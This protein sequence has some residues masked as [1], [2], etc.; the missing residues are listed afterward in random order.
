MTSRGFFSDNPW[1]H[2]LLAQTLIESCLNTH[3]FST[4]VLCGKSGTWWGVGNRISFIFSLCLFPPLSLRAYV[5][6]IIS[7]QGSIFGSTDNKEAV[8]NYFYR[9]GKFP[10]TVQVECMCF[11]PLMNLHWQ[12][13]Q[14]KMSRMCRYLAITSVMTGK[15]FLLEICKRVMSLLQS[16]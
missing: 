9:H 11:T 10:V 1:I 5:C 13:T 16:R 4:R 6:W 8:S 3:L 7:L 15:D 14:K 2:R 12:L